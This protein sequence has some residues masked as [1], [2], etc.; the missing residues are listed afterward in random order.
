MAI[1]LPLLRNRFQLVWGLVSTTLERHWLRIG[2]AAF[3]LFMLLERNLTVE[4]RFS[5]ERPFLNVNGDKPEAEALA[6]PAA[7]KG[8]SSKLQEQQAYVR[9]FSKVA[10][11]EQE[12]FGI[13]A[14]IKLAQGL[15]E[16]DAGDSPIASRNNN[17]FGIKCFSRNCSPGHCSNFSD[18][19]H[20]DFFRKYSNAWESWRAHSL[21][22]RQNPRYQ[23]LFLLEQDDYKGWA[24]GLARA[25]YATDPGYARKLVNLIEELKLYSYDG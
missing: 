23:Q 11:A 15:L 8:S 2:L 17:H 19:S 20:K 12:K 9:R 21:M 7:L 16:S 13:P 4:F 10:Q 22:L 6:R 25:G 1:K 5:T 18:D 24:N 14:S 3:L